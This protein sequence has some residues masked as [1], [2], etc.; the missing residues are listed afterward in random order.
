MKIILNIVVVLL[1]LTTSVFAAGSGNTNQQ[2]DVS[3]Q[4]V[5]GTIEDLS[6]EEVSGLLLMR[7]EEKF[8]QDVYMALYDVWETPIFNNIAS[9]E[10]THTQAVQALLVA[11]GIDD[12]VTD[13][14]QQG[15]YANQELTDLYDSLVQQGSESLLDAFIVGATVEDLDIKDLDELLDTTDNPDLILVYENLQK[16]SRNHMRSFMKQVEAQ[17]GNYEA[18]Y[19]SDDELTDIIDGSQETGALLTPESN[20]D[21]QQ[22]QQQMMR[23]KTGAGQNVRAGTPVQNQNTMQTQSKVQTGT[24]SVG[25]GQQLQVKQQNANQFE[26]QSGN[27]VAQTSMQMNQEQTQT[28]SQLS[29]QLSNGQNAE[30][31]IMPDAASA[32]AM[33]QLQLNVCSEENNCQIELKE[34]AQ[35]NQIKAAYEVQAQ[36]QAKVFGIFGTQMNVR[37]QIDAETG[38]LLSKKKPWWSFLA[39]KS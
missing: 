9:S 8:A 7:E 21:P 25:D 5:G 4:V 30:V 2:Q 16:G 33:Q 26:L 32:Q 14:S 3:N 24:Y 37:A 22:L 1:L 20:I 35:G 17:G 10:A 39:T 6:E 11:Y 13:N 34:F 19:I 27:S 36:K 12:P 38:E 28:G 15:V 31:K 23:G 18:Q 29:V